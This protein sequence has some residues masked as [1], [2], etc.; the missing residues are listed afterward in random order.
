MRVVVYG[1]ASKD[2][3]QAFKDAS[4]ELGKLLAQRGHI[5]VNGGGN[6]GCMGSLS[7]GCLSHGGKVVGVI[8]EMFVVDGEEHTGVSEMLLAGGANLAQRKRLLMQG[9]D[10]LIALPGGVGTFDELWEGVAEVSLGFKDIPIV[11]LNVNGY[12]DS[13][14]LMLERSFADKITYKPPNEYLSMQPTAKMA[15]DWAESNKEA[16]KG[17]TTLNKYAERTVPPAIGIWASGYMVGLITGIFLTGVSCI[18]I[19]RG[20]SR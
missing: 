5:C 9:C 13:F 16:R 2:T 15:L 12:Y 7:D 19:A 1:S 17:K 10:A 20:R 6:T 4:F 11:C 3:P 18:I 14:Q 8:H